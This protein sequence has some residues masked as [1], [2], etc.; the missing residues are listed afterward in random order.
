M[1]SILLA[2]AAAFDSIFLVAFVVLVPLVDAR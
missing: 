1:E 2:T